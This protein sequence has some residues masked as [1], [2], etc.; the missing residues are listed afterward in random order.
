ESDLSADL[1]VGPEQHRKVLRVLA[2]DDVRVPQLAPAAADLQLV[3]PIDV[4]PRLL[5]EP[6]AHRERREGAPLVPRSEGGYAVAANARGQQ[7][8]VA[9]VVVQAADVADPVDLRG[10]AALLQ[11]LVTQRSNPAQFVQ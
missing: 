10:A 7:V 4:E 6:P 9:E 5:G 2:T 3:D 1:V 11:H 8:L